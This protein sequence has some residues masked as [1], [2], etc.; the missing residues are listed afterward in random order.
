MSKDF[1][2]TNQEEEGR[3]LV[4]HN[5]PEG[6]KPLTTLATADDIPAMAKKDVERL[7][8]SYEELL[9][10]AD[11]APPEI[12]S[13]EV[14]DRFTALVGKVKDATDDRETTKKKLKEPY[15]KACTAIE[16]AFKLVKGGD[17]L[18]KRMDTAFTTLK[19]RMSAYD[20]KKYQA[21]E[22]ARQAEHA[23]LSEA[24]AADGI[25]L[26]AGACAPAKLGSQK[27]EHG[28]TSVRSLVDTW[29]VIDE[30]LLPRSVLSIDPKKV[31][32]LIASG[33]AEIP[34]IKISKVV[35][36]SVRRS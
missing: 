21:E 6:E 14:Y 29:E 30:N 26:D 36:T 13:D 32:Q 18:R 15:N 16:N 1:W 20:T 5:L 2:A 9:A 3:D 19:A 27:S 4:G 12:T 35:S 34:G 28:G 33:A 23:R 22:A 24:A 8:N 11:R 25:T 10:I 7:T 31:E 17:D